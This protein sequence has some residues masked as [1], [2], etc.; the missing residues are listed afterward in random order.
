MVTT[1]INHPP[2]Q[3]VAHYQP[4]GSGGVL[5]GWPHVQMDLSG[6]V[7][8]LLGGLLIPLI[9]ASAIFGASGVGFLF[10]FLAILQWKRLQPSSTL[11]LESFFESLT[12][13]I[14]YVRYTAG[15]KIILIRHALFSFISSSSLALMPVLALREFRLQASSLGYVFTAMGVGSV[16]SGV[17][18]I[19]WARAKYLPNWITTRA[20]V[21]LNLL[22]LLGGISIWTRF[23]FAGIPAKLCPSSPSLPPFLMFATLAGAA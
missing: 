20:D 8:P 18:I 21:V 3:I 6:I 10:M 12:T 5:L 9:G 11:P 2:G 17:F 22:L 23:D 16:L 4:P 13:A 15:I 7:G 14:R 1:F 19:P